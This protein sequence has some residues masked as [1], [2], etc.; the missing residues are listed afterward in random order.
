MDT[1]NHADHVV[2]SL[3]S[4]RLM[5]W[6]WDGARGLPMRA[7]VADMTIDAFESET[8]AAI[9][10]PGPSVSLNMDG[11]V[12]V[13]YVDE[14]TERMVDLCFQCAGVVT[15]TKN[16]EDGQTQID[17]VIRL[18][19]DSDTPDCYGELAELLRWVID[20]GE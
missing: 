8:I 6:D 11:S 13:Q 1:K 7:D 15:Y 20:N 18:S 5:Q 10:C 17:G 9:V 4:L 19:D 12:S 14:F 2:S 3:R 16:F